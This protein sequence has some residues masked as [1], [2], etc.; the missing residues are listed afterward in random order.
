MAVHTQPLDEG[1]GR[2]RPVHLHPA[3]LQVRGFAAWTGTDLQHVTAG[4]KPCDDGVQQ[5]RH[6]VAH[7]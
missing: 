1:S 4:A 6:L 3:L 2:V 5:A 7:R